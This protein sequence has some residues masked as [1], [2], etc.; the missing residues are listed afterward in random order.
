[1]TDYEEQI[2]RNLEN[3]WGPAAQHSDYEPGDVLRYR[4][5]GSTWSGTIVWVAAPKESQVQG[6]DNI[7]PL[8]YIV[9]RDG[10]E[11]IPDVVYSRDILSGEAKEEPTL[12][13]CPYCGGHH[14]KGMIAH[15]PNNPNKI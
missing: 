2:K 9:E 5:D 15:C 3:D 4:A 7:L 11:G 13:K 8:R 6:H 10:W 12:E 14:F 1:M